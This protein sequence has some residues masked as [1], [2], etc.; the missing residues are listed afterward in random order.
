MKPKTN[1]STP[2]NAARVII[3]VVTFVFIV[4]IGLPCKLFP[5]KGRTQDLIAH[6]DDF[7]RDKF[8]ILTIL[9]AIHKSAVI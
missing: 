3:L 1:V 2:N 9:V 4:P 5:G 7:A 6:K 8:A